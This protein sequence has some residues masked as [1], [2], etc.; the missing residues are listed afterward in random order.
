MV[1]LA[2]NETVVPKK[3]WCRCAARAGGATTKAEPKDDN[4]EASTRQ[5]ILPETAKNFIVQN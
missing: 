4:D 5:A 3:V 2:D 1:A